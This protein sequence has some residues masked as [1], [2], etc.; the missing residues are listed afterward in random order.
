[1]SLRK[2]LLLATALGGLPLAAAAEISFAPVPFAA[3]D[4]AKRAV[5]ASS[6]VTVDG[7]EY[8]IGYTVLERSG[9]KL[10]EGVFGALIDREGNV[11]KSA[12][13]SEHI[14]VDADFN[15]LLKVGDKIF[16]VT[17]FESRPGAMYV[18][19]LERAEDGTLSAV[20]T[21]PVDFSAYGGLWVPCAGSVTPWNTHLGSE[22]YPS[23]AREI[24]DAESLEDVDDYAFPM[25]RYEG[26]DPANM[27][28]AQF[29]AAYKP[30]RYGY[31]TEIT[32]SEDGTGTPA[33]H[34]AMG[35]VAV[36]LA[37][38]M[39]DQK[40]V[41]I[42][43]DGTN[44]GLFMFVADTAGDLSAG[45][46]Y[47]AKW[48]QTSDESAGA[49]DLEWVDLGH[50]DDASVQALIEGGV[51]F[52]DIFEVADLNADGGCAEGFA[53]SNAEG[54]AECLMVKPG[55]EM[56]ASRLE[57]RRY[58]SMMG[59]TTEFRKMEGIAY[60]ADANV[61]YLAMSEVAKGMED[62]AK[63]DKGGANDIRLAKNSCGAV[64]ELSLGDDFRATAARTLV[65][66]TPTEYPEGS[67][68]AGNTC[69]I[70]GIANPDNLTYITGQNTLIIGE[71]TGTGHQNDVI[72]AMN[73][74]SG[75]LTRIFS[76]PYGSETTSPY[77]YPN[78][79]GH[80]YLVAVIQHPYGESDE[81]KLAD[82]A[83]ARA[84]VGYIGPFPAM[85]K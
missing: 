80:G 39:P 29:R 46:L 14:S 4:A 28:L 65:A 15:S 36:E 52:H 55:M 47:A 19:E 18:T 32:V 51:G 5:L 21:K 75:D 68:Y 37:K 76:T 38:V 7:K 83:D 79:D 9:D 41:Y 84:Y 10:G 1:M 85:D 64:Y 44:V 24:A 45:Q 20:S 23:N 53:P 69:D 57:T 40:T 12:D 43:D 34:F 8:P 26:L 82:P 61:V 72:W 31:P 6:S 2:T 78:L 30:Y 27:T 49:A 66:G 35:R 13:G 3:D 70:D 71:D 73:L 74:D 54:N 17:H 25:V 62:G 48:V 67:E 60:N 81:D 63:Q 33:K 58:A 22:E 11:V 42:S 56:A 50:A 16:S 77:W 59:A